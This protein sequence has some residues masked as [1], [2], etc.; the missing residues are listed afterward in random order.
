MLEINI[1]TY[2][3]PSMLNV[4]FL[5]SFQYFK[6]YLCCPIS[7]RITAIYEDEFEDEDDY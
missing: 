2:I 7:H 4:D 6:Y 5:E 3:K 1:Q